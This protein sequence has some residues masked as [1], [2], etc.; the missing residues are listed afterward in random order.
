MPILGKQN[1]SYEH[2][3]QKLFKKKVLLSKIMLL[4]K[5]EKCISFFA[6]GEDKSCWELW[7]L[8]CS[9]KGGTK[10]YKSWGKTLKTNVLQ[11]W[12]KL[13]D[14]KLLLHNKSVNLHESRMKWYN[15][16]LLF[17]Q[18]MGLY[19]DWFSWDYVI[20]NHTGLS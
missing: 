11:S 10:R 7:K 16:K 6:H 5:M 4:K 17:H 15:T 20:S 3:I 1:I 14:L 18:K 2:G 12:T 13:D 9:H 19:W 8:N